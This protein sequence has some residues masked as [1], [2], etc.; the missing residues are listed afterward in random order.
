MLKNGIQIIMP[1]RIFLYFCAFQNNK[2]SEMNKDLS[3]L[4]GGLLLGIVFL[5][6]IWMVK[7]IGVSTQ[8]VIVDG[9]VWKIFSKELIQ[10]NQNAEPEYSST[11]AYLNKNNGK[12]ASGIANPVNY[13]FIFVLSMILGGFLSS[14]FS[15]KKIQQKD[16]ISPKVWRDKFGE[17]HNKRLVYTF[18]AGFLVLFGARL[19]GG[20]TSGH[21]MSGMMQ[22]SVSG[23]LFATGVFATAIPIAII[24]FKPKK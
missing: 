19:A 4:K 11:N 14:R 8:F 5:T 16:K 13:G 7:P 23:Y 24:F 9:I 12:Y 6:A 3:W 1:L 15:K 10:H 21:M 22:T 2:T 17:N 18:V 20:C